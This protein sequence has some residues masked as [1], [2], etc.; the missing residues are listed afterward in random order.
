MML[1]NLGYLLLDRLCNSQY[2]KMKSV[3]KGGSIILLF[4]LLLSL[5]FILTISVFVVC[6]LPPLLGQ[7]TKEGLPSQK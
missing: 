7:Q 4:F 6:L 1:Q 3:S 2:L 5:F